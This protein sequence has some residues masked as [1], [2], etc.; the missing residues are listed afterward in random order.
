MSKD[1]IKVVKEKTADGQDCFSVIANNTD[2]VEMTAAY[3]CL[4]RSA[5]QNPELRPL[6]QAA[7]KLLEEDTDGWMEEIT[8]YASDESGWM[9]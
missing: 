6:F 5:C 8:M 1:I 9:S 4:I 7:V 2:R 3:M